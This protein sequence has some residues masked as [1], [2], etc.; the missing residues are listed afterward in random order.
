MEIGARID[1]LPSTD[2]TRTLREQQQRLRGLL[3]WQLN[4]D[5]KARLW[6]VKRQLAE[7]ETL[8]AG[9]RQSREDLQQTGAGVT[10]G[11]GSFD[12]RIAAHKIDIDR[13]Q[14]RTARTRLAQGSEIERVAISELENQKKRLDS[15]L[16][17]ARFALAQ[18]YDSALNTRPAAEPGTGR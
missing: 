10:A 11:F 18:T 16:I 8:L 5:Y 9:T 12:G 3:Y 13:L 4:A 1:Q 14:V 15:Y 2:E 6:Q 7:L 17:Q